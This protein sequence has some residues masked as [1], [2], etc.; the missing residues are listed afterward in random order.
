M[1]KRIITLGTWEGKPIE[2]VVLKEEGMFSLVITKTKLGNRRRFN[3]NN[4]NSWI[5]SD[6]RNFLN[7]EFFNN[8][9]SS[10]EKKK[11]VNTFLSS[12]NNTKDNIFLLDIHEAESLI[13]SDDE[14]CNNRRCNSDWCC[15]YRTPVNFHDVYIGYPNICHCAPSASSCYAIR[16][17]MWIKE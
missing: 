9:F 12:P 16:P 6:I 2:W 7:V 8:A 11:I 15:W 1:S 5:Q 10:D 13:K 14:Y 4:N 3:N 17:A